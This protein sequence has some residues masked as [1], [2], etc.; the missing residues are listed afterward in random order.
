MLGYRAINLVGLLLCI[1]S[2]LF[3]ILYLEKTLYLDP[4]PLCMLD[5]VVI[6]MLGA[7]FLIAFIHNPISIAA[8]IYGVLL[9]LFSLIGIGLASRHIWLQNLPKEKVPECGPDIY[10]M[11]DTLPF[12]DVIKKT[13]TGSGSCAE[14]S[15][16]FVGLSIAEQT[17]LLFVVFLLLSMIQTF[18]SRKAN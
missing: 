16:T 15:W 14:V 5:R 3:A 1:A 12:F 2:M 8:K 6:V 17:L 4:C 13:L 7:I 11:L 10:Y 9:L 18:R